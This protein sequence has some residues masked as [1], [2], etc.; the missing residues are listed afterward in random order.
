MLRRITLSLAALVL[1]CTLHAQKAEVSTKAKISGQVGVGFT[2][3][4]PDFGPSAIKGIAIYGTFDLGKHLGV[5]AEYNDL[6]LFTPKDIGESTFF[7]GARYQFTKGRFH[8][9]AKGLFGIGNFEYQKGYYATNTNLRY[10]AYAIGGG[11]DMHLSKHLNIR[12]IDV[13]YQFL[14]AFS[15]HGLNPFAGTVGAAYRF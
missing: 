14:P 1:P 11:A 12:L 13:E 10:P 5:T 15:P 9:Y 3:A 6:K 2:A 4:D 7:Y 8:P